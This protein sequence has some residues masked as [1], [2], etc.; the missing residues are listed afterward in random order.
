[1]VSAQPTRHTCAAQRM[2]T[3][4]EERVQAQSASV[5][6]EPSNYVALRRP[7]LTLYG[8]RLRSGNKTH[9]VSVRTQ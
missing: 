3:V 6:A 1:V 4:V 9:E 7:W 2:T 5:S 8:L